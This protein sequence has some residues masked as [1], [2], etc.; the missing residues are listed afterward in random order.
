MMSSSYLVETIVA[1]LGGEHVLAQIGAREFF[2]D[3]TRVSF[4]FHA[5]SKGVRSVVI[6]ALPNGFFSMDCYGEIGRGTLTAP[7][8]ASAREIIPENLA[9]VLGR[10]TGIESIHHRHF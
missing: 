3:G 10:L 4:R 1:H 5:N 7:K 9:T 6:S 8:I 2:S